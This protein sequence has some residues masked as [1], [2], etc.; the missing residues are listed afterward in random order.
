M[1][2]C[3][4]CIVSVNK[5]EEPQQCTVLKI[6]LIQGRTNYS[7]RSHNLTPIFCTALMCSQSHITSTEIKI[8]FQI[9]FQ[10]LTTRP[11]MSQM[12]L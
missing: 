11:P 1:M 5:T 6:I 7:I 3:L 10:A 12:K 2:D 4:S 9:K 8:F